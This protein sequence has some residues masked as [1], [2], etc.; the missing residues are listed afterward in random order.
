MSPVDQKLDLLRT[1]PLFSRFGKREIERIGMLT[2]E[3]DL[4]EGR[5]LMR[6]GDIGHEMFVIVHGAA[7]V[8]RDGR[9]IAERGDG[10]VVGEM[11]L[12][13]E[14][15]RNGTVT[16]TAASRLLVV[17]HR[18]FHALM[19]EMPQLRLQVL[20]ELARRLSALEPEVSD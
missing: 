15:P 13:A 17:G 19:D 10:D 9:Q 5:V 11:A 6:Q 12:I 14:L 8:E 7:K 2:D 1:I 4:P 20:D 3:V 18:E 16:L